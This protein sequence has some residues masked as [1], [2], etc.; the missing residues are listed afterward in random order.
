MQQPLQIKQPRVPVQLEALLAVAGRADAGRADAVIQASQLVAQQRLKFPL[1]WVGTTATTAAKPSARE[2][3][4]AGS[5][6]AAAI[7]RI[8]GSGTR[9]LRVWFHCRQVESGV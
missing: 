5:A 7:S 2:G 4:K 8:T 3:P 6:R 1:G 9:R